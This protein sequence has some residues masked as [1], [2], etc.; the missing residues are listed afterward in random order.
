M[1]KGNGCLSG[2]QITK[3]ILVMLTD[4]QCSFHPGSHFQ[5]QKKSLISLKQLA[6]K[7]TLF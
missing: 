5:S 4:K 7:V 3:E 1:T 2:V 6:Y